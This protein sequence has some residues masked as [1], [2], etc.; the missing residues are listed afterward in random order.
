MTCPSCPSCQALLQLGLSLSVQGQRLDDATRAV[1][2][3]LPPHAPR[4]TDAQFRRIADFLRRLHD[5]QTASREHLATHT[6]KDTQ[7]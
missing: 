7:P 6:P 4:P 1:S 2:N 3:Q 5:W